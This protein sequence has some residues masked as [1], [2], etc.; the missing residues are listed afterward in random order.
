MKLQL[1]LRKKQI[2]FIVCVSILRIKSCMEDF[3]VRTE[4]Q[5]GQLLA[6]FR[7]ARGLTQAQLARSLG[8]TQQTYSQLERNA[9][10]ASLGRLLAAFSCLGVELVLRDARQTPASSASS[11]IW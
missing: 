1:I 11:G 10:T 9:S 4:A 8:V 5:A 2:Q 3:P 7:K 6:S